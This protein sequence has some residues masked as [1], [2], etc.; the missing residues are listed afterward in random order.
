M[1]KGEVKDDRY[2]EAVFAIDCS[3]NS[4]RGFVLIRGCTG[5]V[6]EFV[7]GG[8]FCYNVVPHGMLGSDKGRV[9]EGPW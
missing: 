8:I 3:T 5:T 7:E 2:N 6:G 4:G 1:C 9:D